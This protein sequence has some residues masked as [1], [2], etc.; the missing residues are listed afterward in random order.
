MIV[1]D[2]E[3]ILK[4]GRKAVVRPLGRRAIN[5]M[6]EFDSKIIHE[7]DYIIFDDYS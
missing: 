3:I 6:I 7:S 1:K 5:E 2:D 4:N